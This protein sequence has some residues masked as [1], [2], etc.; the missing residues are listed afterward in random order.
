MHP[1]FAFYVGNWHDK[2]VVVDADK[3]HGYYNEAV[4]GANIAKSEL[5]ILYHVCIQSTI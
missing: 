3:L 1:E 5:V 4:V 2:G